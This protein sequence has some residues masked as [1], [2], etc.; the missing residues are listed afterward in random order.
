MRQNDMIYAA[1]K[2]YTSQMAQSCCTNVHLTFHCCKHLQGQLLL[3]YNKMLSCTSVLRQRNSEGKIYSNLQQGTSFKKTEPS[4]RQ[5]YLAFDRSPCQLSDSQ[6]NTH[7]RASTHTQTR[8]C[9]AGSYSAYHGET[10]RTRGR[11][12][13]LIP[14]PIL[15]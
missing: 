2:Y 6:G 8:Q 5:N 3:V 14:V 4:Y 13:S 1:R 7:H 12:R 10:H 9:N 15:C 11:R